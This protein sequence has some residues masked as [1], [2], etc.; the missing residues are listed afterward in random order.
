MPSWVP[1]WV[2]KWTRRRWTWGVIAAL[3]LVIVILQLI[4]GDDGQVAE[5]SEA[6]LAP[7]QDELPHEQPEPDALPFAQ[8]AVLLSR[9]L[10][11]AESDGGVD[12]DRDAYQ[13]GGWSDAD[14]DGCNTREQVLI[15][16]ARSLTQVDRH[17]RP[18]DGTWWS[19]Y[20]EIELDDPGEV[21]ID[22]MVPLLEAH[23]S[24]ASEWASPRR[25]DFANDLGSPA[26]LA[27]VSASS[28]QHKSAQ[29]PAEWK[30]PSRSAWC[31]Y[32]R[33]WTTVKVRWALTA[34]PAEIVALREMLAT[35]IEPPS[36][37]PAE[38]PNRDIERRTSGGPGADRPHVRGAVG[39][40]AASRP[41]CSQRRATA[42][43]TVW[44][45]R[46][47]RQDYRMASRS[48]GRTKS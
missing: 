33:D 3:V 9:L 18:I 11:A 8:D 12:Y 38:L 14:G 20:D 36:S 29:D 16:E 19:W 31:Q 30:P 40:V 47:R 34:D 28:N 35:C 32:A 21:Q 42:I 39:V 41:G 46:R 23:Q 25:V 45:A 1:S 43:P 5:P 27:A 22:H 24:G 10:M 7:Q 17:C 2:P 37:R 15:A 4:D 6:P 44:C 48:S 26:S 13:P